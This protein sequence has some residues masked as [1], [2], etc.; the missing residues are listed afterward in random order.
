MVLAQADA[1]AREQ[2]GRGRRHPCRASSRSRSRSARRCGRASGCSTRRPPTPTRCGCSPRTPR[3][4]P[5][6]SRPCSP[7]SRPRSPSRSPVR[8]SWTGTSPTASRVFGR[9][10]TRL[11]RSVPIVADELDQGQHDG[12]SDVLGV[13]PAAMLVRHTRLAG[14]RRVRPGASRRST[15]PSTSACAPASPATASRSCP[16]RGCDSPPTA[17]PARSATAG[18]GR[19]G[20][21]PARHAPRRC[22]AGSPTRRPLA[23]PVHW[24]S[25]C[26]LAVLRSVRLLLVKQ[27]GAI[28]GEFA[29]A[30][31]TMFSGVRVARSP[32]HPEGVAHRRLVG[33]R[34][35]AAAA[36]RGA[37]TPPGR[38]GGA[39]GASA[40]RDRTSCSSSAR[41]ARGCC[42]GPPRHPSG[43][44]PG[45]SARAASAA[46]A[47]CRCR[48]SPSSGAT[49]R[50]AGAT[51]APASS[52][53][54]T[55]SPPCSPCSARSRSG[56]RRSRSCCSGSP[57]CRL[58]R[59][60][61]W[62][63][64]SRLTE[65]GSL[66]AVAALLWVAAPPF[67]TALAEGRP[68]AVV[69]HVL[70]GWLVFAVFG[71]ATSW[72]AAATASLLFAAVI[73][74]APSLAPALVVGWIVAL[75]VSGR[76]AVRLVGLP[77]PA[78]V[79]ALPLVV[80]QVGRGTPF[81]LLAD[82]G[83]PVGGP[84]PS[85]WQLALGLPSG[86]WG[87]WD[88][89]VR[90]HDLARSATRRH[91]ARRAARARRARRGV[92]ARMAPRRP[93][94]RH[95]PARLRHGR[96]GDAR[97]GGDRR[98]RRGGRVGGR[99]AEP[100][101]ARARARGRD[102][103]RR[104]AARTRPDRRRRGRRLAR[105]GG[106]P[107]VRDRHR[108]GAA[109]GR[110]R[111]Q[112][113]RLRGGPG[114]ERSA[115]DHAADDPRAERRAPRDARAR[116]GH[117]PRRP[118]DA[119]PDPHRAHRRR[120]AARRPSR[121]TSPLAAGSTPRPRCASSAASFVLLAPAPDEGREALQTEADG[122]APPSTATPPS[123]RSARPSSARCGDSPPPNR[124][125]RPRRSPRTPEA[126]SPASSR[127]SR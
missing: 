8:S 94:A 88:E 9:T 1:A 12:L 61:V 11:G 10:I 66:R 7:R 45:S 24:L 109:R 41:A 91:G 19:D 46:A 21:T 72:A 20:G 75:A 64:A 67:L 84:V 43:C 22:T 48:A 6:R 55:R 123:S 54:P 14:A 103:A 106:A 63:A 74:A 53:P 44:S 92:R 89:L 32:A 57:P 112:P 33:D 117:D 125:P 120:G 81:G 115:R 3:R 42:S 5:T 85:V 78:L 73:A 79:L 2:A 40:R 76:A 65:R 31:A 50:T 82:P 105:R 39:T 114:R 97:V 87:G 119:R 23:V 108:R 104:A 62:F 60:G 121:A 38:R 95:G 37:P 118:V 90:V 30:L 98:P 56:R 102:R 86:G 93:R 113:A 101:V 116:H 107:D 52:A 28:P 100:R 71:A 36:R 59:S 15:T 111:A 124:M 110:E 18:R 122:R 4:S 25:S 70:L 126:G 58:R 99:R 68:G 96:H 80:E 127:R 16:R 69:A 49:P 29:A 77:I 35:A 27:P 26:P 34:A 13:D 47:C 51:S 17:S 83:V